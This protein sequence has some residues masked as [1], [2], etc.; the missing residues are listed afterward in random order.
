M[1]LA[2]FV[3]VA[4]AQNTRPGVCSNFLKVWEAYPGDDV[5]SD[6]V[7]CFVFLFFLPDV[8]LCQ[9][10]ASLGGGMIGMAK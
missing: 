3:A 5:P 10:L 4:L 6:E 8:F 2:L 9:L 7:G 1:W